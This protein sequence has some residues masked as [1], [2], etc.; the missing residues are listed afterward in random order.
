MPE[1]SALLPPTFPTECGTVMFSQVCVRPHGERRPKVRTPGQDMYPPAMVGTPQGGLYASC[2]HAGGY[3]LVLENKIMHQ[4]LLVQF[5][6]SFKFVFS[7]Q[8]YVLFYKQNRS[9]RNT[10]IKPRV[11]FLKNVKVRLLDRNFIAST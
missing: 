4:S 2:V 1:L 5:R 3:F 9:L 10:L 11:H 8:A 6:C 7:G